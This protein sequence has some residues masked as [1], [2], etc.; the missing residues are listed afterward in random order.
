MPVFSCYRTSL[1][2]GALIYSRINTRY[3]F[4]FSTVT[5][6]DLEKIHLFFCQHATSFDESYFAVKRKFG[7]FDFLHYFSRGA[8]NKREQYVFSSVNDPKEESIEGE[9]THHCL[10]CLHTSGYYSTEDVRKCST[11]DLDTLDDCRPVNCHIKYNGKRNFFNRRMQRCQAVPICIADTSK[12]LP[13]VVGAK[14]L[15]GRDRSRAGS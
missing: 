4:L 14:T 13:D 15:F 5:L 11:V 8:I 12:E 7:N 1:L 6:N 3:N 2:S 10:F 9:I